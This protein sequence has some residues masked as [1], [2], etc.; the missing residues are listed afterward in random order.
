MAITKEQT[1]RAAERI[2]ERG[3]RPTNPRIRAELGEGSYS[4]INK[5]MKEWRVAQQA[6]EAPEPEAEVEAEPEVP[7]AI[8]DKAQAAA[9]ALVTA[10][11]RGSESKHLADIEAERGALT[12]E[13]DKLRAERQQHDAYIQELNDA[14]ARLEQQGEEAVA[15][16]VAQTAQAREEAAMEQQAHGSTREKLAGSQAREEAAQERIEDFRQAADDAKA[17]AADTAKEARERLEKADAEARQ[18]ADEIARLQREL[19]ASQAA[20]TQAQAALDNAQKQ[21]EAVMLD[22]KKEHDAEIDGWRQ[23][24][25][26]AEKAMATQ[27]KRHDA[28]L[29]EWRQEVDAAEKALSASDATQR[30]A[31]DSVTQLQERVSGLEARLEESKASAQR[32]DEMLKELGAST[33]KK[34]AK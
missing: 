14:L 4:T 7:E 21:H 10:A 1:I 19:D 27:Q 12:A 25:D 32:F 11:W 16:E 8:T 29:D 13:F 23:E 9:V 31:T 20:T 24:L 5:Y 17:L 6:Q 28:E 2:A 18:Q 34:D 26:A 22:Q 30:A 33:S 15:A 3:E